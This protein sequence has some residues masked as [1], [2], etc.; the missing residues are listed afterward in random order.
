MPSRIWPNVRASGSLSASSDG[1]NLASASSAASMRR[2]VRVAIGGE[3]LRL[4]HEPV[5]RAQRL[6]ARDSEPARRGA[7]I[8]DRARLPRLSADDD[9]LVE[10]RLAGA[11]AASRR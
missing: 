3:E 7:A 2:A 9:E 11:G 8:E 6:A 4:R 10:R 5:G 1:V